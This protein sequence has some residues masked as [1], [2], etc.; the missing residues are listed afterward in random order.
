MLRYVHGTE[1]SRRDQEELMPKY[2][3]VRWVRYYSRKW[4]KFLWKR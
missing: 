3:L 1:C 2:L 4:E